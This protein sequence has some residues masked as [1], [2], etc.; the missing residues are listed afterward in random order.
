MSKR[1]EITG[2]LR[3]RLRTVLAEYAADIGIESKL[4]A[5]LSM[6]SDASY[7]AEEVLNDYGLEQILMAAGW[8]KMVVKR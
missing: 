4:A 6:R 3:R 2:I 8:R 7:L 5:A 1:E